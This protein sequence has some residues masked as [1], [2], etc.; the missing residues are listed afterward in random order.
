[1]KE[2]KQLFPEKIILNWFVQIVM[3]LDYIHDKKVLH[4]DL[5]SSNI[6]ISNSGTVKIGNFGLSK[7]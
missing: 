2:K 4:R 6:F 7:N 5:K 3:A 1:M